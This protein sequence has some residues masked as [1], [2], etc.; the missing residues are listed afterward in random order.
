M[1]FSFGIILLCGFII[2]YI[3]DKIHVPGLVGMIL[4]GLLFGPYCL[5]FIDPSILNISSELRQMALV[6][7]LTRS[8]LNLDFSSLKKIGRPAILM[9]FLPAT[10]EIIG[11]I[12]GGYFILHLSILESI[13]LG[14]T[15]GAVSPAVVSPRMIKLIEEGY[16]DDK[17][18][19]KLILAGSSVD[20]IYVIVIFYAFLGLVQNNVF[21]YVSIALIPVTI[22]GGVVLGIVM[23]I[24][25]NFVIRK[26]NF[27]LTIN[28]LIM[29]SLSFIMIGIENALK[30]Y[31]D[32]SALLGIIVLAM[33]TLYSNKDK[34][35]DLSK[36]YNSL[37]KFFEILL[38]VLVG[39]S[40]DFS[41]A[42]KNFFPSLCVLLIAL[43]FRCIGVYVCLIMTKLTLKEK[44]F[45]AI[46]YLPKATVQASIGGIALSLGLECGSI[47]LT[48]SVLSILITAPIG[49]FLIDILSKRVLT[50]SECNSSIIN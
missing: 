10:F 44:L 2:G 50:K 24:I 36:G 22:I 27:T 11:S 38:F 43:M 48:V 18:I 41:F 14:A 39:A 47:I 15:L 25:Y 21:D 45:C 17:N 19:P 29:L 26:I 33:I 23:G 20:D 3:L 46:C 8:G 49:A 37:W 1:I 30:K 32:I 7:V 9:C 6:I 12:V 34:A 31:V 16:G 5:N 13:L 35:K 4:L 42:L 40:V 28:I